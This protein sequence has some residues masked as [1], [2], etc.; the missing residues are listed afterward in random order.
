MNKRRPIYLFGIAFAAL[1]VL[2]TAAALQAQGRR[3]GIP[4]EN[5]RFSLSLGGGFASSESHHGLLNLGAEFQAALTPRLRLGLGVG[6]MNNLRHRGRYGDQNERGRQDDMMGGWQGMD[7]RP[8][9]NGAAFRIVPVTLN[10]Y[11]LLPVGRKWGVYAAAGAS[12][13]FGS[14][15]EGTLFQRKRAAGGQAGLGIEY[16]LADSLRVFAEGGYRFVEFRGLKHPALPENPWLDLL[17]EWADGQS[18]TGWGHMFGAFIDQARRQRQLAQEQTYDLNLNGAA[19]R[20]GV[21][22]GF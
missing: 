10:L 5:Q 7:S 11:Y 21:K 2:G 3:A 14:F 4:P 20:L 6:Y 8:T 19:G 1:L 18:R 12:Y 13:H 9:D 17:G 22:F 15:R 16:R